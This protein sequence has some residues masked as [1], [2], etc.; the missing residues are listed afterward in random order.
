METQEVLSNTGMLY[1]K[2]YAA[3]IA[4]NRA[5]QSSGM[6]KCHNMLTKNSSY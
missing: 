6:E 2:I 5:Q 3:I 1:N 4:L